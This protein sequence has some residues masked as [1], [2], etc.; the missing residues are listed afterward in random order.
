MRATEAL[1]EAEQRGVDVTE[2]L[3]RNPAGND[4]A[5]ELALLVQDNRDRIDE[6][7]ATYARSWSL[8]RM[9]AVDRAIARVAV[10]ELL[11]RPDVQTAVAV[12]EAVEVAELLSTDESARYI[13]GLLGA[14]ALVRER[15]TAS[16]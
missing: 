14:V 2:V 3:D 12:S 9:P 15:L 16:E 8:D 13:N 6:V 5:R 1:Y 10:A 7:V 11:L 4:Y